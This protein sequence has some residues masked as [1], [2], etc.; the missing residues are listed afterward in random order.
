MIS[1]EPFHKPLIR[2]NTSKKQWLYINRRCM[3]RRFAPCIYFLSKPYSRKYQLYKE[4]PLLSTAD[5]ISKF[6]VEFDISIQT[7]TLN[8]PALVSK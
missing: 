2:T 8:D 1:Q 5:M 4:K 3:A 6:E 7:W